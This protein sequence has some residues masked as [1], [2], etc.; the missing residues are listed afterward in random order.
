MK[1]SLY[2]GQRG[3][4]IIE[5]VLVL[6]IAGLIFLMVF[7]ALPALQ[8]SQRDAARRDDI[9]V[10]LRKVKDYQ[11]NNRGALPTGNG[12]SIERGTASGV[13]WAGFYHDYL[14][15]N[16]ADPNGSSY[17]LSVAT[18]GVNSAGAKCTNMLSDTTVFP[19]DYKLTIF[20]GAT[21][22]GS[23]AVATNN[24]RKIAV[25]YELEGGG[26]ICENT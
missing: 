17:V 1:K 12:D 15:E 19:N 18:C 6:G 8:R 24:P 9:L 13:D 21:C 25:Q 26:V 3:F 2:N 14:E 23:D 5:V 7:I 10:F 20:K 11:T 16:F 22:S 4:T